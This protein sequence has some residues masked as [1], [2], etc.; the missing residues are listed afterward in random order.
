MNNVHE[1]FKINLAF[2]I[3]PRF[4]SQISTSD[5]NLGCVRNTVTLS[6]WDTFSFEI[7]LCYL[8]NKIC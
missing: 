1:A 8:S 2:Q 3:D 7:K 6:I 4:L 5:I